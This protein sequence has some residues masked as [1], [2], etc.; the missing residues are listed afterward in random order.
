[1][2]ST[3]YRVIL[4]T[5]QPGRFTREQAAE[6]V[7]IAIEKLAKKRTRGKKSTGSSK[8]RATASKS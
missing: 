8:T 5:E 1:M 4:D 7:R 3:T 2:A 6:A